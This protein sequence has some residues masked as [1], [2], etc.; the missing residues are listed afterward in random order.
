MT[1][2]PDD[3]AGAPLR[4]VFAAAAGLLRDLQDRCAGLQEALGPAAGA[5]PPALQDLDYVTQGLSGLADFMAGLA[6]QL[7]AD[8][9]AD[10]AALAARLPLE[11]MAAALSLAP[12]PDTAPPGDLDLFD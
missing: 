11:R 10:A 12:E 6:E 1:A 3:P 4:D 7:P 5:A 9:T 2:A 8:L